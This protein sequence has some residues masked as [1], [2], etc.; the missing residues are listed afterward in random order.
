MKFTQKTGLFAL[1]FLAQALMAFETQKDQIKLEVDQGNGRYNVRYAETLSSGNFIPFFV[2]EDI[3]TS[4][5]IL[6]LGG[7]RFVLGDEGGFKTEVV[8]QSTGVK[9]VWT[10]ADFTVQKP[11]RFFLLKNRNPEAA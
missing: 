1:L 11:L 2:P 4:K 5:D 10:R 6:V 9:I 3:S 7:R 8:P